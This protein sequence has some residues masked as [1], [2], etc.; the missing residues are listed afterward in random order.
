MLASTL[1]DKGRETLCADFP[2]VTLIINRPLRSS[3]TTVSNESSSKMRYWRE[4]I[5]RETGTRQLPPRAVE[6]RKSAP[7]ANYRHHAMYCTILVAH[8]AGTTARV[9]SK[10][11]NAGS[12]SL[13]ARFR[14]PSM[15]SSLRFNFCCSGT[16]LL[17]LVPVSFRRQ[18]EPKKALARA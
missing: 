7:T 2:A 8:P 9:S 14:A 10:I 17:A 5:Q 16:R 1:W 3:S 12:G 6:A 15:V 11:L 18:T 4:P 13:R